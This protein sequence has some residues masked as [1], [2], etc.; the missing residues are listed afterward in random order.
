MYFYPS[1]KSLRSSISYAVCMY[2]ISDALSVFC[3]QFVYFYTFS[4][5]YREINYFLFC[6]NRK[7]DL[8]YPTLFAGKIKKFAFSRTREETVI[9]NC[10][11]QAKSSHHLAPSAALDVI[12]QVGC[13]GGSVGIQH[14]QQQPEEEEEAQK[15]E[16]GGNEYAVEK[17]I[18]FGSDDTL[19][20]TTCHIY[21]DMED[22][23]VHNNQIVEV[24]EMLKEPRVSTGDV[25]VSEISDT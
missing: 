3:I 17:C 23:Y 2:S 1:Y 7:C 25:T 15:V 18:K 22:N 16:V 19:D 10:N 20:Y 11:N 21:D 12:R 5:N 8:I 13:S 14:H 9:S 24:T 4:L 6:T